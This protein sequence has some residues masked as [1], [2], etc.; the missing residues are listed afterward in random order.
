[1]S[2]RRSVNDETTSLAAILAVTFLASLGTGAIWHGLAFIAKHNYGFDQSRNLLLHAAMGA[3]YTVGAFQAGRVARITGRHMT[4]RTLLGLIIGLQTALCILPVAFDA[5]WPLWVA[6]CGISLL[7]SFMWPLM[8]SYLTAGRHG[9]DMRRAI[10][11]FN[12][13]WMPAMVVSTR[14]M[15][16]GSRRSHP[17]SVGRT[18]KAMTAN[19]IAADDTSS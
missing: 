6:A 5:Q 12:L 17:M 2:D 13:T 18:S 4:P 11:W 10:G 1:M 8:E 19:L 15:G 9:R 14:A 3:V 7:A 16:A